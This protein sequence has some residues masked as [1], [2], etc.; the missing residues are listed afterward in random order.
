M[1]GNRPRIQKKVVENNLIEDKLEFKKNFSTQRAR[2]IKTFQEELKVELWF[3]Q[4]YIVTRHQHGEDSGEKRDGISPEE[5][6]PLLKKSIVH[7]VC[8]GANVKGFNFLNH[9]NK[10]PVRIVVKE[11]SI[12]ET[13]NVVSEVHLVDLNLYEMTVKTAMRKD[14]FRIENGR[15]AIEFIGN[16]QSVL[17]KQEGK[18]EIEVATLEL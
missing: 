9:E 4:H 1:A 16:N 13:L 11:R 2:K 12:G 18:I 10:P 8:Y 3:D 6:E 5:V 7:L 15:F 14:D 17:K